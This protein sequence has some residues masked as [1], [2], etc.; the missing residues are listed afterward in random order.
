M[1][2]DLRY[3]FGILVLVRPRR[4]EQ[5]MVVACPESMT[6][7]FPADREFYV[8][9][10]KGSVHESVMISDREVQIGT[11][12]SVIAKDTEKHVT[13][14]LMWSE[15]QPGVPDSPALRQMMW[16]R[17]RARVCALLESRV[18]DIT[19]ETAFNG[20]RYNGVERWNSSEKGFV[21]RERQYAEAGRLY[22][23][24]VYAPTK[25]LAESQA[26]AFLISGLGRVTV[27][28]TRSIILPH[29]QAVVY[30]IACGKGNR[31]SSGVLEW[32]STG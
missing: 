3:A 14:A 8:M 26:V 17:I 24:A 12:H 16:D 28:L 13:Y 2:A 25:E 15:R 30:P 20:D 10:P 6:V 27:S 11:L 23:I 5:R 18:A 21:L 1:I 9:M 31:R 19:S 7:F 32:W 4:R 29:L 22:E